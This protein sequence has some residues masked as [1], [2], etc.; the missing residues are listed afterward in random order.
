M[1]DISIDKAI[2]CRFFLSFFISFFL[3]FFRIVCFV[4]NLNSS[5]DDKPVLTDQRARARA[6]ARKPAAARASA[7]RRSAGRSSSDTLI[8]SLLIVLM[9]SGKN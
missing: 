5:A 7:R 3:L 4:F 1:E 9:M 8:Y 2:D 6:R